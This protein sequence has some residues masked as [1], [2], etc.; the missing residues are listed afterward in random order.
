MGAFGG[1]FDDEDEIQFGNEDADNQGFDFRSSDPPAQQI[2]LSTIY[3]GNTTR[4]GDSIGPGPSRSPPLHSRQ[5]RD[6]AS[7][8][9]RGGS[10]SSRHRQD[11]PSYLTNSFDTSALGQTVNQSMA[12]SKSRRSRGRSRHYYT[13]IS[14]QQQQITLMQQQISGLQK[15]MEEQMRINSLSRAQTMALSAQESQTGRSTMEDGSKSFPSSSEPP[16]NTAT[17]DIEE[18]ENS[19]LGREASKEAEHAPLLTKTVASLNSAM[20]M[21]DP[22]A[23]YL[24]GLQQYDEEEDDDDDEFDMHARKDAELQ[25]VDRHESPSKT[26]VSKSTIV[27]DLDEKTILPTHEPALSRGSPGRHDKEKKAK[28]HV[29]PIAEPPSS[30][31]S[32]GIGTTM[33]RIPSNSTDDS[34]EPP[35]IIR[36]EE[37]ETSS[38]K[39]LSHS[40]LN[41]SNLQRDSSSRTSHR[42]A[43]EQDSISNIYAEMDTEFGIPQIREVTFATTAPRRARLGSDQGGDDEDEEDDED[44]EDWI[45]AV[46][47]KYLKQARDARSLKA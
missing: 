14:T 38:K 1:L 15:L 39:D 37:D 33:L 9:N 45:A 12:S 22:T 13:M 47:A 43:T 18:N 26:C 28:T 8:R 16:K 36:E 44:D 27:V 5:S 3:G 11:A 29:S 41:K 7:H 20:T 6:Q 42:F 19:G 10:R 32:S 31:L 23:I 46:E 25:Q 24:A 17:N 34:S 2:M 40:R 35:S 21:E 30:V 4:L